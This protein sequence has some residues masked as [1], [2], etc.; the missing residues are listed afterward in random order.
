MKLSRRAVTAYGFILVAILLAMLAV[1]IFGQLSAEWKRAIF[2]IA[3]VLL[4]LRFA[5]KLIL[6]R[7]E[8][9]D[10]ERNGKPKS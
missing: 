6:G 3:L 1:T 5:L 8:R 2:Y 9:L 4:L 7:Q 10:R